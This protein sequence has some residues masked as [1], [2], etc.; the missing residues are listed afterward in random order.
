M[1]VAPLILGIIGTVLA[2]GSLGWQVWSCVLQGARPKLTP[3]VGFL[4][5]GGLVSK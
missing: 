4:T 1:T 3:V 5:P 2:A